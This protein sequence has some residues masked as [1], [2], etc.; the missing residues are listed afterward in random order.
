MRRMKASFTVEAVFVVS[1]IC[2]VIILMIG[3]TLELYEET[4][5][6]AERCIEAAKEEDG[7]I[8]H[9]RL[10][11]LAGKIIGGT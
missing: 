7:I 2:I 10:E 11:R 4:E 3:K 8:M 5:S 6:L 9:M 1:I